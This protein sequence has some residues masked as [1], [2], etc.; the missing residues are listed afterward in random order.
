MIIEDKDIIERLKNDDAS[1]FTFLFN[2]YYSGLVVYAGHLLESNDNSADIVHDVFITLWEK[3]KSLFIETS[4]KSYLFTSVR[5]R[6][7]NYISHLR[8][9]S[10]YQDS[11]LKNGDVNGP[12]TWEY[13]DEKELTSLIDKAI[14]KLP[15]QCRK[16][17]EMSRFENKTSTEIANELGISPRTAEKHIQKALQILRSELKDYLPLSLIAILFQ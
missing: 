7:L 17:F 2:R 15:S 10:E 11:I 9:R 14:N 16:V 5:N 8:V 3:R 1:F 6:C 4:I 13:Y 12:L